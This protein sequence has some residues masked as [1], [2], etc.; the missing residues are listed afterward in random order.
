ME[1]SSL[2]EALSKAL[3]RWLAPALRGVAGLPRYPAG[4]RASARDKGCGRVA[5]VFDAD[6]PASMAGHS[7]PDVPTA[8]LGY[9]RLTPPLVSS[10]EYRLTRAGPTLEKP[11]VAI[12][13]FHAGAI[14]VRA[15]S[16]RGDLHRSRGDRQD[17]YRV[18]VSDHQLLIAVSDGVS[19]AR[20]AAVASRV[21]TAA[22]IEALRRDASTAG[23]RSALCSAEAE[24][25]GLAVARSWTEQDLATTLTVATV[26]LA[27]PFQCA[28]ATVGDTTLGLFKSDGAV[29]TTARGACDAP[30]VLPLSRPGDVW[31]EHF[32]L[33]PGEILMVMTDGLG[34]GLSRQAV[35]SAL[36]ERLF[37]PPSALQ[38]AASISVDCE[39]MWDDRT[40]VAVWRCEADPVGD[41]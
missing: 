31:E 22:A 6:S 27:E 36:Q 25:R 33:A 7:I 32:L 3:N 13:G 18:A 4:Q 28:T 1:R 19:S 10:S 17:D 5:V 30:P 20:Y 24:L 12:D 8:E 40:A 15:A 11:A 16:M 26:D 35:R 41:V 39:E 38:F 14:A 21:A 29:F 34:D 23:L 37:P 2:H 9:E